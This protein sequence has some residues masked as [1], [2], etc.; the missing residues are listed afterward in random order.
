MK[1]I[2]QSTRTERGKVLIGIPYIM[3]A[4]MKHALDDYY[5]I[6]SFQQEKR[7]ENSIVFHFS[8]E[9]EFKR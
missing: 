8:D 5:C 2:N 3:Q 9:K 7:Q 6:Y 1:E 4:T